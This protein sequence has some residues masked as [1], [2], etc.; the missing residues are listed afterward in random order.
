L[1]RQIK[2]TTFISQTYNHCKNLPNQKVSLK[3][4]DTDVGRFRDI[5]R[6]LYNSS[7][8]PLQMT[9]KLIY[10]NIYWWPDTERGQI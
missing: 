8:V 7:S 10:W 3:K 5:F 6:T 4:L 1:T 2:L 9:P